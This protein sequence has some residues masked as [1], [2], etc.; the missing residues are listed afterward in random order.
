MVKQTS[1][2]ENVRGRVYILD[3][4]ITVEDLRVVVKKELGGLVASSMSYHLRETAMA[5]KVPIIL[6][7][8]FGE[9]Q[10]T[11][12][13][14]EILHGFE[15]KRQ[16]AFDAISPNR[17]TSERPEI[18][19]PYQASG[20]N[21]FEPR[22][23]AVLIV[24]AT[25]RLSRAPHEGQ[26]ATVSDLPDKPQIMENGLR[27]AAAQVKLRNGHEV[28]VPLANIELMGEAK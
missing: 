18:V 7:E 6:T 17:W 12:R 23:D 3:R 15:N 1:L 19:I 14:Y 11:R 13:I 26:I 20:Q 25:V 28:L 16:A 10:M 21:A 5:L 24:G 4:P 8:G 22:F 27:V 2:L 9:S